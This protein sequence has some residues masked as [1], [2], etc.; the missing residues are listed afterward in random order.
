MACEICFVE[1]AWPVTSTDV[2]YNT[3]SEVNVLTPRKLPCGCVGCTGCLQDSWCDKEFSLVCPTCLQTHVLD[4][5]ITSLPILEP[6][7]GAPVVITQT[8]KYRS[9]CNDDNVLATQDAE[10]TASIGSPSLPTVHR[11]KSPRHASADTGRLN[12]FLKSVP[13]STVPI[14][15]S[16]TVPLPPPSLIVTPSTRRA[17]KRLQ[18]AKLSRLSLRSPSHAGE[19]PLIMWVGQEEE[20]DGTIGQETN[21]KEPRTMAREGEPVQNRSLEEAQPKEEAT[22]HAT[23]FPV[24][25]STAVMPKSCRS[26][27]GPLDPPALADRFRSHQLM[28]LGEIFELLDRA[29]DILKAEPNVLTLQAPVTC[30]G[31]MHGQF[32]DLLDLFARAGG[33][34]GTREHASPSPPASPGSPSPNPSRFLFLGDY[35]DRGAYSCEVL[36]YLLALKVAYPDLIHL[37][38]GN[39]ETRGATTFFGFK[40]ECKAKYGLPVYYR[41]LLVFES[42]PLCAVVETDYGR[43]F[44]CHGGISPEIQSLAEIQRIDRFVEP[45]ASGSL[46]DLLWADPWHEKKVDPGI[47]GEATDKE[48]V[49]RA[50]DE[51]LAV[52]WRPNGERGCSVYFG[53]RAIRRFLDDNHLLCLIRAHQVQE[54]G[55]SEHFAWSVEAAAAGGDGAPPFPSPPSIPGRG[56]APPPAPSGPERPCPPLASRLPPRVLP[57]VVTIFSAPNYCNHYGNKGAF[58]QVGPTAPDQV[59]FHQFDCVSALP[60]ASSHP[61][62]ARLQR[63]QEH[64]LAIMNT[65]PYMPTTFRELLRAAS[66]LGVLASK[67]GGRERGQEGGM[68]EEEASPSSSQRGLASSVSESSIES[69][70][71]LKEGDDA[72]DGGAATT[73]A[74]SPSSSPSFS[75]SSSPPLDPSP[76]PA[77]TPEAREGG[78][79]EGRSGRRDDR[80]AW[81]DNNTGASCSKLSVQIPKPVGPYSITSPPSSLTASPTTQASRAIHPRHPSH[82]CREVRSEASDVEEARRTTRGGQWKGRCEKPRETGTDSKG[83]DQDHPSM[84][85]SVA[86]PVGKASVQPK[87]ACGRGA[88]GVADGGMRGEGEEREER[89][90]ERKEEA[91]PRVGGT[92]VED[93]KAL[94]GDDAG[95]KEGKVREKRKGGGT[96]QAAVEQEGEAEEMVETRLFEGYGSASGCLALICLPSLWQRRGNDT[97]P[98]APLT[99]LASRSQS[100]ENSPTLAPSAGPSPRSDD[101]SRQNRINKAPA[102]K[103]GAGC[104][105]AWFRRV[106]GGKTGD[107]VVGQAK[108][109]IATREREASPHLWP[110]VSRS[111]FLAFHA[112]FPFLKPPMFRRPKSASGISTRVNGSS[113][114]CVEGRFGDDISNPDEMV[115]RCSNVTPNHTPATITHQASTIEG[116]GMD[117]DG[118]TEPGPH[119]VVDSRRR[120]EKSA[121]P[122]RRNLEGKPRETA[123]TRTEKSESFAVHGNHNTHIRKATHHCSSLRDSNR[124]T[125]P[126]NITSSENHIRG[127]QHRD[128]HSGRSIAVY[129]LGTRN[130]AFSP[131]RD[132]PEGG[133]GSA[134]GARCGS[135]LSGPCPGP[136]AFHRHVRNPTSTLRASSDSQGV[137]GVNS[138]GRRTLSNRGVP[139]PRGDLT[140]VVS[141]IRGRD[142]RG[143]VQPAASTARDRNKLRSSLEALNEVSPSKDTTCASTR[144][145]RRDGTLPSDSRSTITGSPCLPI[146]TAGP[147]AAR[148][149]KVE[150]EC[151]RGKENSGKCEALTTKII[152]RSTLRPVRMSRRESVYRLAQRRDGINEMHPDIVA[153]CLET[154]AAKMPDEGKEKGA[155]WERPVS[156]SGALEEETAHRPYSVAEVCARLERGVLRHWQ[157]RGGSEAGKVRRRTEPGNVLSDPEINGRR[158]HFGPAGKAEHDDSRVGNVPNRRYSL[159]PGTT[160]VLDLL[161]C[162]EARRQAHVEYQSTLAGEKLRERRQA[163]PSTFLESTSL[164]PPKV[165]LPACSPRPL[166]PSSPASGP[167]SGRL[168]SPSKPFPPSSPT[169]SPT[170]DELLIVGDTGGSSLSRNSR[171]KSDPAPPLIASTPDTDPLTKPDLSLSSS[172]CPP[173]LEHEAPSPPFPPPNTASSAAP[174]DDIFTAG[175]IVTLRLIFAL[176]DDNGDDFLEASE[177]ERY[178][179]EDEEVDGGGASRTQAEECVRLLDGDGDG[180]IGLLDFICFA[181]RLKELHRKEEF[182]LVLSDLRRSRAKAR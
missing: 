18:Q 158:A 100:N 69:V 143:V 178:A 80:L 47:N 107:P 34:P 60:T 98:G 132:R 106:W 177:L 141:K 81:V 102:Q 37:L 30:V 131:A 136:S 144:R 153:R 118:R 56:I 133:R 154:L 174:P 46:C 79:D 113:P 168:P 57:P 48:Q 162:F 127:P 27:W 110:H 55:Y 156:A 94:C 50:W 25:T 138:R 103:K 31:D 76:L 97:R 179:E 19:D 108:P 4:K 173:S 40:E 87:G 71:D 5:D 36:L 64:H 150:Q 146:R 28:E 62:W 13:S 42:L 43:L 38:R 59:T 114:K 78:E 130:S 119:R 84:D 89:M 32:F 92:T 180:K 147:A 152:K 17:H 1:F 49:A 29:R 129:A 167:S 7:G 112:A 181:A 6:P 12:A 86:V 44:A 9:N 91:G 52:E 120:S 88:G 159:R 15:C 123:S 99:E 14:P 21:K 95:E 58:L 116:R 26:P 111:P 182:S 22:N 2:T 39:H 65:C 67:E 137:P 149:G 70:V 90:R 72:S 96:G 101:Q 105:S 93:N 169:S 145:P 73:S 61:S 170:T 115:A 140:S 128:S 117:V 109:D 24:S 139:E 8:D 161:E 151:R 51:Y 63:H 53:Y 157:D 20:S 16:L 176:F 172:C 83:S 160:S 163:T 164:S 124:T 66:E 68:D 121:I 104:H 155:K 45:G 10:A 3:I 125:I 134:S 11:V 23:A 126:V 41:F 142:Q 122:E 75:S 135:S 171:S 77:T 82:A 166:A 35:V 33:A 54:E 85:R 165:S 74:S 148:P 175:E